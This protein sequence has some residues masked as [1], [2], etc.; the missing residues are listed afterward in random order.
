MNKKQAIE[1]FDLVIKNNLLP[2]KIEDLGTMSFIG[3]QAVKFYQAA[4]KNFNL[5]MSDEQRKK[6][7]KD[8]QNAGNMLLDIELQIGKIA[9]EEKQAN[10]VPVHK[11]GRPGDKSFKGS[12]PSGQPPKH[13]RLG[14]KEKHMRDAQLLYKEHEK[15]KAENRESPVDKIRKQAAE[16]EDIPT[17]TA[18]VIEVRYQKEKA[19]RKEAEGKQQKTKLMISIDQTRYITALDKCARILPQKPPKDW[20]ENA[21][22]EAKTKAQILIKR[23]EVFNG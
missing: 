11:G 12:K 18:A 2:T 21:F 14:L 8:G 9:A 1:V 4:I 10:S 6:I 16:A 13:E 22:K 7:L 19:R 3:T 5:S 23:L 20:N 15:A 17:K